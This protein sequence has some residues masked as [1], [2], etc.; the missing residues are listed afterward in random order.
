[1]RH[2]GR[3][4]VSWLLAPLDTVYR[5]QRLMSGGR[6][7]AGA[8][9]PV[10]RDWR[11]H[12]APFALLDSGMLCDRGTWTLEAVGEGEGKNQALA[13]AGTAV[14][15]FLAALAPSCAAPQSQFAF[16]ICLCFCLMCA[17]CCNG[18]SVG[19]TPIATLLPSLTPLFQ[20]RIHG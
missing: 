20:V 3:A 9:S 14:L 15:L 2:R 5:Q 8:S 11:A 19:V 6:S 4:R 10:S 12:V 7:L 13:G 16:C 1:M 18:G 17:V